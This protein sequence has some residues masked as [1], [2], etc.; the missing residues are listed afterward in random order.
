M[1]QLIDKKDIYK[2]VL[3]ILS[4]FNKD[5]INEI[6]QKVF[7]KLTDLAADSDYNIS[8]DVNKGIE[9]QEISEES[10]DIIALIYY[11]CIAD[12]QEKKELISIWEQNDNSKA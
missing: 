8:I 7:M 6:P 10:K 12:E 1:K 5:L 2:E 4:H 11:N 3:L 9:E